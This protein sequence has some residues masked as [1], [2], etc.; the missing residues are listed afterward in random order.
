[1]LN[2]SGS[3]VPAVAAAVTVPLVVATA[4]TVARRRTIPAGPRG[5]A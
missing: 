2:D 1:L 3:A 5:D 4:A